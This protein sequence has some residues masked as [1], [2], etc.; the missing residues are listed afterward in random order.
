MLQINKNQSGGEVEVRLGEPFEIHLGEN[1]TTGYRWHLRTPESP[2]VQVQEDTF[3]GSGG[4]VG[5]GG[6]RRWRFQTVQE[7]TVQ[8]EMEHR[9]S[10]EQQAVDRFNIKVR[11][12]GKGSTSP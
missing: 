8:V 9:R 6:V 5:A 7:G 3:Q 2:A 10:W 1:P 12:T 4:K 11:V